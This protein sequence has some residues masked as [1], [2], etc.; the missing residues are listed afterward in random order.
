MDK[1]I[2]FSMIMRIKFKKFALISLLVI[3]PLTTFQFNVFMAEAKTQPVK[4]SAVKAVKK[5]VVKPATVADLVG[6]FFLQVESYNRLWYVLPDNKQRYYLKD[7]EDWDFLVKSYAIKITAK[8]IAKIPVNKKGKG[9]VSIVNKYK[10]KIVILD[11]NT[12]KDLNVWY[13]N[14]GD[15]I[16]YPLDDF[17][18]VLKM[19]KVIA[20]PVKNDYLRLAAMNNEQ[21]TFDSAFPY[22]SYV[23]YNGKDFSGGVSDNV[24]L[25]LA[26]LSK[27]MTALIIADLNL[28][29]EKTVTITPEEI[30]YPKTLVGNDATSE[31]S[32]KAGDTVALKDLWISM[33]TASSNQSAVVLADASGLTRKEF[34]VKMN[35]KAKALGL[36]KTKFYEMSGL[37]PNN[38]T[39]AREM[40][41]IAAAA[42]KNP[43]IA[44]A[45]QVSNY[46]FFVT[47]ADGNARLVDVR[48]RNYSLLAM[49]ADAS[50]TGYLVEAQRNVALKKDGKIIVVMHS[51]S[52]AQRNSIITKLNNSA[53]ALTYLESEEGN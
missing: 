15:G 23:S 40:A 44:E 7:Q 16:R 48:N 32:L 22:V 5:P 38:V 33:L 51:A 24:I 1:L 8:D 49:G 42:F 21:L 31:V 34:A 50:K 6:K 12:K 4:V 28:D 39:T 52:M 10:G 3:I 26:S 37:D 47:Q 36:V 45:T 30:N 11:Q 9:T 46:R 19:A 20:A 41:L 14:P 29:M 13:V 43:K 2:I 27:L 35:E 18:D 53:P 17:S 25:P